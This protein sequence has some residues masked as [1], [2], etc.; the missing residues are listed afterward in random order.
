MN[1]IKKKLNDKGNPGDLKKPNWAH[2]K[3]TDTK[4]LNLE[5]VVI[6]TVLQNGKYY[7]VTIGNEYQNGKAK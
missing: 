5:N 7:F 3:L 1:Y 4:D 6:K 2:I